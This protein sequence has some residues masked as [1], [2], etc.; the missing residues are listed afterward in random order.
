MPHFGWISGSDK[1]HQSDKTLWDNKKLRR[2]IQNKR[3]DMLTKDDRLLQYNTRS[4]KANI[5]KQFLDLV[6]WDVLNNLPYFPDLSPSDY[7][8]F[9]SPKLNYLS[10]FPDL[11]PSD[12]DHFPEG[13]W[14]SII[15]WPVILRLRSVDFPEVA[16]EWKKFPRDEVVKRG[17]EV[18]KRAGRKF[19]RGRYEKIDPLPH[20]FH[21]SKWWLY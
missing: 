11:S 16:H 4:H 3:R 19:G 21:R 1:D 14:P 12:Y 13:E 2:A 7:D 20:Q 8:L 18:C 6:G 9:T 15:P 10:Y 17:G 5:T